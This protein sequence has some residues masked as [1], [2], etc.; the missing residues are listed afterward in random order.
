MHHILVTASPFLV[1]AAQPIGRRILRWIVLLLIVVGATFAV[2]RFSRRRHQE[3]EG[4]DPRADE[5][6]RHPPA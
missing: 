3:G 1:A 2:I 4:R 6:P 5:W